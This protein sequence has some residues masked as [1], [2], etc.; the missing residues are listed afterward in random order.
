MKQRWKFYSSQ[1]VA[2]LLNTFYDESMILKYSLIVLLVLGSDLSKF[3][4]LHL[5]SEWATLVNGRYCKVSED[6]ETAY[7]VLCLVAWIH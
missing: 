2:A 7:A 4:F 1:P 6:H 5:L 3:P